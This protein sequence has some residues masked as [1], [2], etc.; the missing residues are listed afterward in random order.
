MRLTSSLLTIGA[1]CDM[2][3]VSD[4]NNQGAFFVIMTP[5]GESGDVRQKHA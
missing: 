4:V 1:I 5:K 3:K 2:I